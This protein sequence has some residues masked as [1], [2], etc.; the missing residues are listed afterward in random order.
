[1]IS[2]LEL[3]YKQKDYKQC[4]SQCQKILDKDINNKPAHLLL[5]KAA[6]KSKVTLESLKSDK[7]PCFNKP[8]LE[9]HLKCY[10]DFNIALSIPQP[11]LQFDWWL[12]LIH[13]IFNK[14][15]QFGQDV[16]VSQSL[17]L[18]DML[19]TRLMIY[20]YSS[21]QSTLEETILKHPF[22]NRSLEL[23]A[24]FKDTLD[25]W[26]QLY[27]LDA[28]NLNS[29]SKVAESYIPENPYHALLL[30]QRMIN[31][32]SNSYEVWSNAAFT[33]YKSDLMMYVW[34][35]FYKALK[36]GGDVDG[37]VWFNIGVVAA[38]MKE[39]ELSYRCYAVAKYLGIECE[40][41]DTIMRMRLNA[42]QR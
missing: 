9:Y 3:Y 22:D 41:F 34:I 35:C 24:I 26:K 7:N 30:Y 19:F 1:M 13:S 23:L 14:G 21:S 18:N 28:S 6:S 5:I 27:K 33:S 25:L 32:G 39:V 31:C 37:Q 42:F 17:S 15:I 2:A 40:D 10:N 16:L 36:N 20:K 29:L 8:I 11:T 38:E 12:L 4:I